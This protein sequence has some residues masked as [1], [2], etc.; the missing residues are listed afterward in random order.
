MSFT[1]RGFGPEGAAAAAPS[2]ALAA[3]AHNAEVISN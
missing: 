1:P 3:H 2:H